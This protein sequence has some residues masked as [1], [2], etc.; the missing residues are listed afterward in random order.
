MTIV[1][2]GGDFKEEALVWWH[3]AVR[4]SQSMGL[5][6]LDGAC[7]ELDSGCVDPLCKLHVRGADGTTMAEMESEEELRRAFW[8]IFSLDR[9]LALSF[10]GNLLIHDDEVRVYVPLPDDM[11][12]DF[13][14]LWPDTP[15]RRT[16]GPPA[17]VTG[18]GFYEYFLPLMTLLGDVIETHRR[19]SHPR[20]GT[21]NDTAAV[22]MIEGL[23]ASCAQSINDLAT[24]HDIDK[25]QNGT[26][27]TGSHFGNTVMTPS[28]NYSDQDSNPFVTSPTAQYQQQHHPRSLSGTQH[29]LRKVRRGQVLLVTSY[30]RFIVNVLHV[31][32]NGKWDAVSSKY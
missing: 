32:L 14:S 17:L 15:S 10:N 6:R 5:N 30:A 24:L 28:T 2:S 9:H 27:P 25:Y 18:T 12:E 16:Y 22:S 8:L 26:V 11:W 1:V 19:S 23:L 31:L 7:T 21:L 13:D 29:R 4:L 20:L 3:K